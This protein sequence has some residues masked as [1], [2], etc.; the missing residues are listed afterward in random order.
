M[1]NNLKTSLLHFIAKKLVEEQDAIVFFCN[2]SKHLNTA[3]VLAKGIR[4][5]Q[6]NPV[7]LIGDEFER[8][9]KD[10]ES[11]M[12]NL[13][14]GNESV[15]NSLFLAATNYIDKVPDTLKNRPSRFKVV[16]EIRGI[17]DK[18][19]LYAIIRNISSKIDPSLFTDQEITEVVA[20]TIDATMDEL[21]HICLD[22]LTDNY[23]PK[24]I[25][26]TYVGFHS[27][28][29]SVSPPEPTTGQLLWGICYPPVEYNIPSQVPD[30]NI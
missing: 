4:E 10:A 25:T 24:Q 30:S 18:Q 5:I 1:G 14:D 8:Y 29:E 12:K 2:S 27:N 22:K 20:D 17:T 9:A 3:V 6:N 26:R 13:L 15:N 7:I 28:K 23:L 19:L 11:E 16:Q 21:K